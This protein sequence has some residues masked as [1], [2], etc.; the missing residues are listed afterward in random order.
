MNIDT[1][2][3]RESGLG[4]IVLFYT[5]CK[6]VTQPIQRIASQLVE[7][8]SRPILKRSAS[9]RDRFIPVASQ[10][11]IEGLRTVQLPKL[12]AILNKAREE[13]DPARLKKHSASVPERTLMTFTVAPKMHSSLLQRNPH[14][15]A[16]AARRSNK[17][18]L[19]RLQ[20]TSNGRGSRA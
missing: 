12:N 19:K 15:D 18:L 17:E 5:K 3:L 10:E 11:D 16:L 2:T 7:E 20:K 9:Y 8:W 14:D 1:E 4:R 6:R 13:A